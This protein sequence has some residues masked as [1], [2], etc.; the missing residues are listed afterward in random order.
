MIADIILL[1]E[2]I[3]EVVV[4]ANNQKLKSLAKK[5]LSLIVA[6]VIAIVTN[7]SLTVVSNSKPTTMYLHLF[8]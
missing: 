4:L 3:K 1:H 6:I 8:M 5:N 2:N 7:K